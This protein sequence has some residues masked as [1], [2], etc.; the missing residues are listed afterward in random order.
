MSDKEIYFEAFIEQRLK[1]LR[2]ERERIDR[3][4]SDL[5]LYLELGRRLGIVDR[6]IKI[7][8]AT[9]SPR[10][11][12]S[13]YK[14][15]K[16]MKSSLSHETGEVGNILGNHAEFAED[17]ASQQAS[18]LSV[19]IEKNGAVSRKYGRAL[20]DA[21]VSCI[22]EAGHPL[23]AREILERVQQQGFSVPGQDPVASLNTRLWKRS[24]PGRPLQRLGDAVYTLNVEVED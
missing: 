1:K 2:A 24:G 14:V 6:E 7:L 15:P 22:N 17:L 13:G 11:L 21:A 5:V 18:D 3:E 23:H 19:S 9:T 10:N 12:C 16:G 20:V 4:I 8:R